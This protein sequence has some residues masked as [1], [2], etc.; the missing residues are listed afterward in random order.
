MNAITSHY[1]DK[2]ND[3]GRIVVN[4]YSVAVGR[5]TVGY[6]DDGFTPI[7]HYSAQVANDWNVSNR[8]EITAA[9]MRGVLGKIKRHPH[10]LVSNC[11]VR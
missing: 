3:Y 2:K 11:I 9:T 7:R 4:G 6:K 5:S 8:F 10:K 1:Y